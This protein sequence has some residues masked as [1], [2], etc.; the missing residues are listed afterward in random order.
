VGSASDKNSWKSKAARR[1][2]SW[3][4]GVQKIAWRWMWNFGEEIRQVIDVGKALGT[5]LEAPVIKS[6]AGSV[7]VDESLSRRIAKDERMVYIDWPQN[8][9]V[10]FLSGPF[11]V[12]LPRYINFDPSAASASRTLN[13]PFMTE[14]CIFQK[15]QT[16]NE[17]NGK[18]I[19][20]SHSDPMMSLDTNIA[21]LPEI[22][23]SKMNRLYNF[24]GRLKQGFSSFYTLKRFGTED[25]TIGK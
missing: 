4:V 21:D 10:G 12:Q 11:L 1:L 16:V 23:C 8:D 24:E 18:G 15:S 13:K 6:V 7:C 17:A 9:S 5:P 19:Q 20:A 22:V 25:E 2:G 3:S 14:F